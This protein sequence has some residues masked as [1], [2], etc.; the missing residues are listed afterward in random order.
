[1]LALTG[2]PHDGTVI[3]DPEPGI[4]AVDVEHFTFD[5][6]EVARYRISPDRTEAVYMS[7]RFPLRYES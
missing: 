7:S 4:Q 6:V 1:M 3:D 5:G 2:G